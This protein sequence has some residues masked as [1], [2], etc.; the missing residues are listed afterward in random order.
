MSGEPGAAL[1]IDAV[2]SSVRHSSPTRQI[3]GR[4]V[5]DIQNYV[6]YFFAAINNALSRGASKFYL[7]EFGVGIAEWRILAMLAIEPE[8]PA[9]RICEVVALDKSSASRG[10][11]SLLDKGLLSFHESKRD[12]RRRIWWLN[13]AGYETHDK[14][15][16]VALARE[17]RLLQE[18][19]AAD[20][21]ITLR[22]MRQMRKNVLDLDES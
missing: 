12:T 7:E 19:D 18:V 11:K 22:V 21:E 8:I 4:R 2:T 3:A 6:P 5:L 17:E 10:L 1:R 16:S 20:L 13:E 15:L 14:I 9:T